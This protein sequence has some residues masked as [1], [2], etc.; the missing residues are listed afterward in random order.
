MQ[1]YDIVFN[2]QSYFIILLARTIVW[3]WHDCMFGLSHA[4][5]EVSHKPELTELVYLLARSS[6]PQ[7]DSTSESVISIIGIILF[8]FTTA[9][10][11]INRNIISYVFSKPP[12]DR[13]V[14]INPTEVNV[15]CRQEVKIIINYFCVSCMLTDLNSTLAA[16][17]RLYIFI[18]IHIC[19][20]TTIYCWVEWRDVKTALPK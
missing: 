17:A 3:N 10:D 9:R 14:S 6:T 1:R 12:Y 19:Q 8:N 15:S 11:L 16:T 4:S 7:T 18:Y 5:T 13:V 20:I 2:I